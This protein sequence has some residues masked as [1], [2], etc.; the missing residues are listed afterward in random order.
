M[1]EIN[2]LIVNL[3]KKLEIN[4]TVDHVGLSELSKLCLIEF[5]LNPDKKIK[6][7]YLLKIY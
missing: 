5:A 7:E 1:L 2:G 4:L 3:L 6:P